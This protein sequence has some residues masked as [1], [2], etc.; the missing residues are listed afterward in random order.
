[1]SVFSISVLRH[2]ASCLWPLA[3]LSGVVAC[4][5]STEGGGLQSQLAG[6]AFLLD[7]SEG[8]TPVANTNV[9]LDLE[10]AEFRF[11]A[12]C[13]SYSGAYSVCGVALCVNNLG[14][15]EIGCPAELQAQDQWLAEFMTARPEL[16]LEGDRLTLTGHDAALA[17][18]DRKVADPDR[19]LTGRIWTIDTLIQGDAA[20]NVPPPVLPAVSLDLDG[21]VQ[22]VTSSSTGAG[23]Y[24]RQGS[25]LSLS[26][27][28][29]TQEGA[30]ATSAN[31]HVER[32]LSDGTLTLE[33][34]AARLTLMHGVDGVS[35][36]TD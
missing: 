13:N 18:L 12:G 28:A 6:R 7:S 11:S 27:V 26:N 25:E 29:Y 36:T 34:E 31:A 9:R 2:G 24:V 35:A 3:L 33:I 30:G 15:T 23:E 16:S 14:S 32:V 10:Q 19:P 17:F 21:H 5:D 22:I 1:M 4:G 8:F 20:S